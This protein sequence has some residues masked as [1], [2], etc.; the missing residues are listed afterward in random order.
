MLY[1]VRFSFFESKKLVLRFRDFI[2]SFIYDKSNHNL[3]MTQKERIHH[4]LM[5]PVLLNIFKPIL[6]FI[7]LKTRFL[8]HH[9][10]I[11][12]RFHEIWIQAEQDTVFNVYISS[13]NQFL[14]STIFYYFLGAFSSDKISCKSTLRF[15][16]TTEGKL[17]ART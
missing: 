7:T 11:R 17:K 16:C 2:L 9:H 6:D 15:I 13:F 5:N 14:Q 3:Q 12:R 1:Y 10:S 4:S 8:Q